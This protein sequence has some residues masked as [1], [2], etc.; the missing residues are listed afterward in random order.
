MSTFLYLIEIGSPDGSAFER[1]DALVGTRATFTVVPSGMLARLGVMT[2]G[3][4]SFRL[5]DGTV[6]ER[7]IGETKVR[8]ERKTVTAVVVFGDEAG[9]V[10]LGATTLIGCALE[11]HLAA[12]KLAPAVLPL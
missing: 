9:P 2:I 12:R 10:V 5:S 11:V 8:I 3:K 7:D 6:I 1:V 4:V